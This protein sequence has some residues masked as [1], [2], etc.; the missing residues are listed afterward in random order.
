MDLSDGVVV[1]GLLEFE[2]LYN[3]SAA[4]SSSAPSAAAA[5]AQSSSAAA[6][7]PSATPSSSSAAAT[8]PASSAP[9]AAAHP[10]A[11][12][13]PS[14]AAAAPSPQP[15]VTAAPRDLTLELL[16][17]C[18]VSYDEVAA[19]VEAAPHLTASQIVEGFE[20]RVAITPRRR[21]LLE[22]TVC[23]AVAAHRRLALD[24]RYCQPD[25]QRQQTRLL[26]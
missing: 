8:A 26:H 10:S 2:D 14:A 7:Q 25:H 21:Q 15:S 9:A 17:F 20:R 12:S 13:P 19:A 23:G 11:A 18:P 22:A 16:E 5:A 4:P 3:P 6:S 1:E 24:R